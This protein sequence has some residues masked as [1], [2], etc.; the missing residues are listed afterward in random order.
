[1]AG[2]A[3][4]ISALYK[5]TQTETKK[6]TEEIDNLAKAAEAANK[7]IWEMEAAQKL[8]EEREAIIAAEEAIRQR[9]GTQD[10][11][12]AAQDRYRKAVRQLRLAES[13]SARTFLGQLAARE[14]AREEGRKRERSETRATRKPERNETRQ[15]RNQRSSILI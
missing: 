14:K 13:F 10:Q 15:R 9:T 1:M 12:T 6:T 11:L 2:L 7:S 3:L 5:E 8:K 4:G